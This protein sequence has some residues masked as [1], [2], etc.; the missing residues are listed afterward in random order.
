MQYPIGVIVVSDFLARVLVDVCKDLGLS[1]PKDVAIVA[2][3]SAP[4]T[5][6]SFNPTITTIDNNLTEVGFRAAETL[7]KIIRGHKVPI[8]QYVRPHD[9]VG[10]MSTDALAVEDPLVRKALRFIWDNISE[11]PSVIEVA[12]IVMFHVDPWSENSR[13]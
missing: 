5:S 1:V 12:N 10:R 6:E 13:K 8:E 4:M 2:H 7:D 11:S 3:A 9:I